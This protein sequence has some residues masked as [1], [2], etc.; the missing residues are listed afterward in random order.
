[1]S[2][3]A[4]SS[5]DLFNGPP[6]DNDAQRTTLALELRTASGFTL[7]FAVCSQWEEAKRQRE[8]L[9]HDLSD[10]R[11]QQIHIPVE[12][13]H[14]LDLLRHTLQHP[15]PDAVFVYGIENWIPD[16]A[17]PRS[18]PFLLNLNASR[19]NFILDCPVPVVLW[20]PEYLY[21]LIARAA[22]DFASV[23]SGFYL[24]TASETDPMDFLSTL[25]AMEPLETQNLTAAEKQERIATLSALL[26]RIRALPSE[27]R[28]EE[29]EIRVMGQLAATYHAA[30]LYQEELPLR[31]Q[32][33]ALV[34]KVFGPKH[35]YTAG[36]LNNLGVVYGIL[37]QWKEAIASLNTSLTI[38]REL[39]DLNGEG[40]T[41]NNIGNIYEKQEHWEEA[42]DCYRQSLE[43]KRALQDQIG[44]G[45][46]LNNI[47]IVYKNLRRWE[48]ALNCYQQSL[49]IRRAL[50]DRIG[51][52]QTLNN[53]GIV[54]RNQRRWD[55]AL[56]CFRQSL[57]IYRA[58]QDRMGEGQTLNNLGIVYRNQGRWDEA[59]DCFR[60][61]LEIRRAFQDRIGEGNTLQNIAVLNQAQ[62][63]EV[64]T[65]DYMRQALRAFEQTQ[66][67]RQKRYLQEWIA[68]AEALSAEG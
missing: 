25:E 38:Q 62:G 34:E 43:I 59:L 31:E 56:D 23:R 27:R 42:L 48:E 3:L 45:N 67:E 39:G 68:K 49:E 35:P 63:D 44:E 17:N 21:G 10:L 54:Y 57:G 30:G 18:V 50:Q 37:G 5:T 26:E 7:I 53:L 4:K 66:D 22:P 2:L 9:I 64:A 40:R 46:T 28:D 52:G 14:L 41:L 60:Q 55:E 13:P 19:N 16:T 32:T 15:L 65:L 12:T 1:M 61:S 29:A 47:G 58:F 24:F 33:L 20:V 6:P 36:S 51:E 8:A 11:I